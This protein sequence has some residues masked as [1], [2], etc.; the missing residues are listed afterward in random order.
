MTTLK[1]TIVEN[2]PSH[3]RYLRVVASPACCQVVVCRLCCFRQACS[4]S[5]SRSL[6]GRRG[7]HRWGGL[8][9]CGLYWRLRHNVLWHVAWHCHI[10]AV[11]TRRSHLHPRE[12][13]LGLV[14]LCSHE[15]HPGLAVCLTY[16]ISRDSISGFAGNRI[17]WHYFCFWYGLEQM[18][19]EMTYLHLEKG[20]GQHNQE[21]CGNE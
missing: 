7:V 19:E 21:G 13:R 1:S 11:D 10:L 15:V 6:A 4:C 8:C 3:F 18:I 12:L 2:N 17:W 20:G 14:A 9:L 16:F 5:R